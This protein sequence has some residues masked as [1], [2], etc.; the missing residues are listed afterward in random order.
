[1]EKQNFNLNN[2]ILMFS[3]CSSIEVDLRN[4][5]RNNK[6]TVPISETI[7]EK[8]LTRKKQNENKKF[9]IK[10]NP[11][12]DNYE[13]LVEMDLK[14]LVD[15]ILS[16]SIQFKINTQQRP[17]FEE[18]FTQLIPIRNRVMHS[19]PLEFADRSILDEVLRTIDSLLPSIQWEQIKKT[20][21]AILENPQ[22][23]LMTQKLLDD[24]DTNGIFHNLPLPE[25]DDTGFV[26]RSEEIN[27]ITEL[28]L[29][30]KSQIITVV[31]NGGIG[32][33][34][35]VIKCLYNILDSQEGQDRFDAMIWVSLKTKSLTSGEFLNIKNAITSVD[36]MYNF[37]QKTMITESGTSIE[38]IINFMREFNTLLIID[39][40][41][42]IATEQIMDFLKKIPESSK[43]LITSRLGLGEL[44]TRYKLTEMT[45]TDAKKY[46]RLLCQ[47]YDLDIYK[48]DEK[49]LN[50]LIKDDLYCSPL[51][52]KWF[53]TSIYFGA[54]EHS[55]IINKNELISFS[56]SNIID[57]LSKDQIEILDLFLLQG[58]SM[59]FGEIDFYIGNSGREV[60]QDI[61]VL[62]ST[63]LLELKGSKYQIN[64]MAKD[65]LS[66]HSNLG[67]EFIERISEKRKKLNKVLRQLKEEEEVSPFLPRSII[68]SMEDENKKI[69][70]Y[71]L[72]KALENSAEKNWDVAFSF[73]D[74]AS[75]LAP[76]YFEVYKIRAYL[77]T[78]KNN[79]FDAIDS[80]R[81]AVE[82]AKPGIE[83]AS[84]LYLLSGFYKISMQDLLEANKYI[85][86]ALENS[87]DSK[88]IILEKA[89]LLIML[90]HYDE[91]EKYLLSITPKESDTEKFKNQYASRY[92]DLCVR[93]IVNLEKRDSDK[94]LAKIAEGFNAIDR[95]EKI[96]EATAA[97]VVRALIQLSFIFSEPGAKELFGEKFILYFSAI[98]KLN[99]QLNKQVQSLQHRILDR[100]DLYNDRTIELAKRLG[101]N[102][103]EKSMVVKNPNEGFINRAKRYYGFVSN[104][105]DSY[106]F[107]HTDVLYP[108]PLVGDFVKFELIDGPVGKK[109]AIKLEKI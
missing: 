14:E 39:N 47:Y 71:Y 29:N 54:D 109:V 35:T 75:S 76:D 1:M 11:N 36:N 107:E 79:L 26:G 51:S 25:F 66:I 73:V 58:R 81:T 67:N 9:D 50:K 48:R 22:Q 19:R 61:N 98:V 20:R 28:I 59:V 101:V 103:R 6:P 83:K 40:L 30:N 8:A 5:I 45:M 42:T 72:I 96:D 49:D 55:L 17:K 63:S 4:F 2:R 90:S 108:E 89:R 70:S 84:V 7:L 23:L 24:I 21:K 43:V 99:F 18:I 85:D 69:A 74:R 82:N 31:G 52:I 95:L 62:L 56:M 80:Y 34:A 46:F 57:R 15:L 91:A 93:R 100:E 78:I 68:G 64:N 44:E 86:E 41:E 13:I 60:I 65:Y 53:I 102:Y 33:T 87:P 88:D 92:A 37:I 10:E 97:I 105:F 38:E 106:Y 12:S 27:D 77:N 94:K 3:V 104:S 16:K 32:K